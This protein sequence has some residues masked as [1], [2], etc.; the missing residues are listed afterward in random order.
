MHEL[1]VE[2]GDRLYRVE[3]PFGS[4]PLNTG[5]ARSIYE[6]ARGVA[7]DIAKTET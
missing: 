4:W 6:N 5:L 7:R 3:R 2:L 1:I